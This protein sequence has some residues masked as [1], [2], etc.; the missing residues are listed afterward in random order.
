MP[1]PRPRLVVLDAHTTTAAQ[2]G[3]APAPGEPTWDA[4]AVLSELTVHPR[5]A[6]TEL[7]ERAAGAA[8]LITNKTEL[9]AGVLADLPDLRYIGLLS[10][11]T[12]VVDLAAARAQNVTVSNAPAYSTA[13]VAQHVFALLFEL[14]N[15]VGA[16]A[17]AVNAGEWA[18]SPD[19]SFTLAPLHELSGQTLGIVGFGDIGQAAARIGAALGMR[20][21]VHTRTEKPTDLDVTWTDKSTLLERSDVVTLHS[22]LTPETHHFI[23][24]PA[25]A[26]MKP[27]A[28]LINTGR[29]PLV[30]EPALAH[31]LRTGQLAGA[32]LD[33]LSSEPPPANHPLVGLPNC[34]ITPHVAWA[35]QAARRRL[36]DVVTGNVQAFLNGNPRHVVN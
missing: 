11:G 18:N 8:L 15:R 21:L 22:P 7:R 4:L 34:I 9:D 20:I 10:T 31:A 36:M 1:N 29:G 17:T 2:P 32:G 6:R 16:H 24:A 27:T 12:N 3:Q 30:D 5:T 14:T 33:V 28:C 25:L 13:S 35:T 23:D 19:F 26:T